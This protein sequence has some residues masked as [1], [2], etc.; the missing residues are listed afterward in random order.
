MS[1][2]DVKGRFWLTPPDLM[3]R[4]ST[5]FGFD[6]DAAPYP[7]PAG[8]NSLTAEWGRSTWVNPPVDHG[9]SITA[10]VKKGV[11]E[12]KKG[13]LVVMLLPFPRWFRYLLAVDAEFRFP[14]PI[15]FLSP[16]GRRAPSE[17]GGRIPDILAILR[18]MTAQSRRT[19]A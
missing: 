10:W 17:G 5:E 16:D 15:H 11:E 2:D 13:K 12:N 14:G 9:S 18:P 1:Q 19:K 8:F 7:R 6:F 3:E 4:L